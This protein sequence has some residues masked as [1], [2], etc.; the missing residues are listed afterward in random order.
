MNRKA[1][2]SFWENTIYS[3]NS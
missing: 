2:C 1:I 3:Q